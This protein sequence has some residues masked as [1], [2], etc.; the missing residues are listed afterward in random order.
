MGVISLAARPMNGR[1]SYNSPRKRRNDAAKHRQLA[2]SCSSVYL[3]YRGSHPE[4][5]LPS[6]ARE[7]PGEL[8]PAGETK[9]WTIAVYRQNTGEVIPDPMAA[10]VERARDKVRWDRHRTIIHEG[11]PMRIESDPCTEVSH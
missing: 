3:T 10:V 2:S 8:E 5:K 9:D 4:E 1:W 7:A 6:C 11:I